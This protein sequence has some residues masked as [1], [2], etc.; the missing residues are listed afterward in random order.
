MSLTW[1]CFLPVLLLHPIV[2]QDSTSLATTLVA[3]ATFVSVTVPPVVCRPPGRP[4]SAPVSMITMRPAG[5]VATK[6]SARATFLALWTD[7]FVSTTTLRPN[8]NVDV[9]LALRRRS[10][11]TRLSLNLFMARSI[12]FPM[13]GAQSLETRPRRQAIIRLVVLFAER[14]QVKPHHRSHPRDD[15]WESVLREHH[16]GWHWE[17]LIDCFE[18]YYSLHISIDVGTV[19]VRQ[20]SERLAFK[21]QKKT[22]TTRSTH[23]RVSFAARNSNSDSSHTT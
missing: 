11:M 15:C 6:T 14:R 9:R 3:G 5:I 22:N 12:Q 18:C 10:R 16:R 21:S 1:F 20:P 7:P 13:I 4:V 2:L 17:L 23:Y 8:S 19:A